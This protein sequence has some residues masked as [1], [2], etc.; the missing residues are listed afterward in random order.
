MWTSR[1]TTP[2]TSL[3][4]RRSIL[5]VHIPKGQMLFQYFKMNRVVTG[6]QKYYHMAVPRCERLSHADNNV[7]GNISLIACHVI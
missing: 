5:D 1:I 6:L 3:L 4:K 7:V 2:V